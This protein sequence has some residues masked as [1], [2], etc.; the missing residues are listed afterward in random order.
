[1]PRSAVS[2]ELRAEYRRAHYR[3]FG[4]KPFRLKLGTPSRGLKALYRQHSVSTAVFLTAWNPR[5]VAQTAQKNLRGQARLKKSLRS[6]GIAF[7]P[8]F[9]QDPLA[10]HPGEPSLLALGL[11]RAAAV[12]L[13]ARFG[14]NAILWAGRD[15]V[16]K[17]VFL[18]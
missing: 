17:L 12:A 6:A 5:S 18:R 15:R 16:P 14:Q 4:K 11:T 8:A 1:M 7:L 3:I 9:G 13:G 2:P 10:L